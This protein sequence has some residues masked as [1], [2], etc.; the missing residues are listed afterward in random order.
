MFWLGGFLSVLFSYLIVQK[1]QFNYRLRQPQAYTEKLFYRKFRRRINWDKPRDFNEKIH[2]L[3]FYSNT[4]RWPELADKYR[5]RAYV[6]SKGLGSALNKLYAVYATPQEIDLQALPRSF[7]LK[8]NNGSGDILLVPDKTKITRGKILR[9]FGRRKYFGVDTA[10][11]HYLKIPPKI[12]VEK[13]LREDS[14]HS[15]SL[16]D[17]KFFCFHGEPKYIYV[18]WDRDE[19]KVDHLRETY[20]SRWRLVKNAY[21][22]AGRYQSRGL[23]RPKSFAQMQKMCR[24]LAKGFPFVRVDWYEVEGRPVFGEMTFTPAAGFIDYYT[25]AFLQTLGRQIKI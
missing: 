7:A 1:I 14:G 12:I 25:P 15:A 18:C 24:R 17:Y 10:E 8:A 4:S 5:V 19:R 11:P 23:P 2:W 20:D 3:K 21:P 16:I 13:L 6:Q 22:R 9:H